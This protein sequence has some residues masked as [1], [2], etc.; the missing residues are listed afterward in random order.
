VRTDGLSLAA[1]LGGGEAGDGGETQS[2]G[3]GIPGGGVESGQMG[4]GGDNSWGAKPHADACFAVEK[5]TSFRFTI[6]K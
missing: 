6:Q 2:L 3:G 4:V 1:R 5:G